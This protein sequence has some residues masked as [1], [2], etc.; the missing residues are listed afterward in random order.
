MNKLIYKPISLGTSILAGLLADQIFKRVWRLTAR[1]D[2]APKATD[3]DRSWTEVLAAAAKAGRIL[4]THD[5]RTM[6]RH[7]A[8]FLQT[9]ASPGVLLVSQRL[10]LP[11]VVDQLIL[12]WA[13]SNADEWLNRICRLPL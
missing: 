8:D 10:P 12:I 3:A 6:P 5:F 9:A 2:E 4:V 7:F 1:E 13:A 11:E